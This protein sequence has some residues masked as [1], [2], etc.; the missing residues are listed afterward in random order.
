MK[1]FRYRETVI[2]TWKLLSKILGPAFSNPSPRLRRFC[3]LALRR[4]L[5]RWEAVW[6]TATLLDLVRMFQPSW[7]SVV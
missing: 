1:V 2:Q 7:P 4:L 5:T 3:F 6:K